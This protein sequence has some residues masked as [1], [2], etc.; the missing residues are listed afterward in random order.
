LL[1]HDAS[2]T[3]VWKGRVNVSVAQVLSLNTFA[4]TVFDVAAK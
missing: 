3:S 4:T 1:S 2:L